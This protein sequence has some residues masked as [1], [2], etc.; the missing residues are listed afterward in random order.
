MQTRAKITQKS[1]AVTSN[2]Q[3]AIDIGVGCDDTESS[4]LK[5]YF[6]IYSY[7]QQITDDDSL[8]LSINSNELYAMRKKLISDN[9][10]DQMLNEDEYNDWNS[11]EIQISEPFIYEYTDGWSNVWEYAYTINYMLLLLITISLSNVFS[12]EYYRK[13]RRNHFVQPVW[14]KATIYFK[15]FSWNDIQHSF[16][17]HIICRYAFFQPLSVWYRRISCS[18][19]TCLSIIIIEY[20]RRRFCFSLAR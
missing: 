12:I 1:Q 14:E 9:R 5:K 17:N 19:T 13:N 18:T 16:G 3:I 4:V 20:K 7:V 8:T 15:N 2:N 11:K 10:A 6:P